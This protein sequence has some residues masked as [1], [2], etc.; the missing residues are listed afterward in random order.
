M[1]QKLF[2]RKSKKNLQ[3]KRL[4]TVTN[5]YDLAEYSVAYRYIS[6]QTIIKK[7]IKNIY[8]FYLND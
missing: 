8:Q 1:L 6:I 3:L 7:S 2:T 5:D 4:H